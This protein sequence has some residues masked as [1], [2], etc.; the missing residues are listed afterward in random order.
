MTIALVS[1]ELRAYFSLDVTSVREMTR[2]R[3]WS[4]EPVSDEDDQWHAVAEL[5][6]T[7]RGAGRIGSGEF[8]QQPVRGRTEPLLMF[9]PG[10]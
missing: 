3:E 1:R 8:V 10:R 9:L 6:G 4:D 2:R 5:V 7:G